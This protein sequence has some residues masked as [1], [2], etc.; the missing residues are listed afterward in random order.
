MKQIDVHYQKKK[1]KKDGIIN[2]LKLFCQNTAVTYVNSQ[3]QITYTLKL[4]CCDVI[5]AKQSK[6]SISSKIFLKVA[7][8]YFVDN[9]LQ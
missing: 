7:N 5:A 9:S 3:L 6:A 4:S 2:M 8:R 1:K